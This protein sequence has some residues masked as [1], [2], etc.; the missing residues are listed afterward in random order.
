MS[1]TTTTTAALATL[2]DLFADDTYDGLLFPS[3]VS[4]RKPINV[5]K[6]ARLSEPWETGKGYVSHYVHADRAGRHTIADDADMDISSRFA[7]L[8]RAAWSIDEYG[9]MNHEGELAAYAA[10]P[11]GRHALRNVIGTRRVDDD[12]NLSVL[13]GGR[14]VV[15]WA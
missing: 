5:S 1:T 11:R 8:T 7:W 9:T 15:R 13:V 6:R 10:G 4:L 12:G 2:G 14:W 3:P